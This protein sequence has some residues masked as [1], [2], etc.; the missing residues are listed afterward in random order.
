MQS[1]TSLP[2]EILH[3]I[4]RFAEPESLKT[5]RQVCRSLGE[6]GKERLFESITVYAKEESCDKSTDFLE[7]KDRGCLHLVT[8]VYLDLSAF[9][10]SCPSLCFRSGN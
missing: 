10:V 6:I 5:L 1:L 2:T 8:K 3:K 7:N 9:E 4:I